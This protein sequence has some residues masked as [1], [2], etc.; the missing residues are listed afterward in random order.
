[1]PIAKIWQCCDYCVVEKN[2][3]KLLRAKA[4]ESLFFAYH[5]FEEDVPSLKEM[6]RAAL[7]N[8]GVRGTNVLS[9]VGLL[10]MPAH[11]CNIQSRQAVTLFERCIPNVIY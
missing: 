5:C 2:F 9:N 8:M 3:K 11:P 6:A 7:T 4:L 1:M 10:V